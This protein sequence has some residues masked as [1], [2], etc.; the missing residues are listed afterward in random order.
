MAGDTDGGIQAV[1]AA[2]NQALWREVNE[3]SGLSPK[4]PSTW[5]FSASAR[6]WSVRR[7]SS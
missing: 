4:H 7:P 1:K 6:T 5:S 3:K 2:R